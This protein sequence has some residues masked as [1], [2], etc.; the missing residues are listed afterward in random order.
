MT[1]RFVFDFPIF[2]I[3]N[4]ADGALLRKQNDPGEKTAIVFTDDSFARA[5]GDGYPGSYLH[6]RSNIYA[7]RADVLS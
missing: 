7:R 3:R 6:G 5:F 4:A 1:G 2:V